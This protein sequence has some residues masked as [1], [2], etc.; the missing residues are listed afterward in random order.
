MSER[1]TTS[2]ER[3]AA[4]RYGLVLIVLVVLTAIEVAASYLT[5]GIKIGV[6]IA[7]AVAKAA[8]VVMYFMHLKFD[9]RL[10]TAMF[11]LG[12]VLIAPLLF[13]LFAATP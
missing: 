8:L 2:E 13:F 1:P 9:T 11:L 6:L 10:Y 7:L 12:L 3:H 4:P 5:G